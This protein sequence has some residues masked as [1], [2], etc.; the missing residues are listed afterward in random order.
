[1]S[2]KDTITSADSRQ[3]NLKTLVGRAHHALRA[4]RHA[5]SKG[6]AAGVY[7]MH[8]YGIAADEKS[9]SIFNDK[10]EP[11]LHRSIEDWAKEGWQIRRAFIG[12]RFIKEELEKLREDGSD[13]I[14]RVFFNLNV[15]DGGAKLSFEGAPVTK[16]L[17][18]EKLAGKTAC[19][20]VRDPVGAELETLSD[21]DLTS[22][23]G[24]ARL[25]HPVQKYVLESLDAAERYSFKDAAEAE[26]EK[27]YRLGIIRRPRSAAT[28]LKATETAA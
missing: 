23:A 24:W 2:Q 17:I 15:L 14:P 22:I 10:Q 20:D 27:A 7:T 3:R 6:T 1:M 18:N 9:A 21:E 8:T 11:V 28:A 26:R 13:R 25:G 19:L 5:L 16:A 4:Y 12:L